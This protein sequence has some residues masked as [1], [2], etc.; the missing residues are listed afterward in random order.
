[1]L[2]KPGLRFFLG[3]ILICPLFTCSESPEVDVT[4]P[5]R[6][7]DIRVTEVGTN[8]VRL[9]WTAPGD[10]GDKGTAAK[11]DIRYSVSSL[12]GAAWDNAVQCQGEHAPSKAGTGEAFYVSGLASGTAYNFALRACDDAGNWSEMSDIVGATTLGV[13]VIRPAAITDLEAGHATWNSIHLAW[14][15][16][17][18]DSL[19]GPAAAYDIRYSTSDIDS[20][21]WPAAAQCENEPTPAGPGITDSLSIGGLLPGTKYYFAMRVGDEAGNWSGISNTASATTSVQADRVAPARVTDLAAGDADSAHV[22]L[23]WTATGDDGHSGTAAQ[24]DIR[25]SPAPISVTTWPSAEPCLNEPVPQPAGTAE[26]YVMGGLNP[27]STY[28]FA[29]KAAD[30]AGNWSALSNNTEAVTTA[31]LGDTIPPAAISSIEAVFH[32]GGS[33]RLRWTAVGDDGHSGT[34]GAFDIR[35]MEQPIDA[36]NWDEAHRLTCSGTCEPVPAGTVQEVIV[37]GFPEALTLYYVAVRVRDDAFNWSPVSGLATYETRTCTGGVPCYP[38]FPRAGG[39]YDYIGINWQ[40]Y[41]GDFYT[42]DYDVRYSR[43]PIDDWNWH[44]STRGGTLSYQYVGNHWIYFY[45][46]ITG[47]KPGTMYYIGIRAGSPCQDAIKVVT[48]TTE[49]EPPE[50]GTSLKFAVH[51]EDHAERSCGAGLPPIASRDDIVRRLDRDLP[52]DIDAFVVIFGIEGTLISGVGYGLTWP[53]DWG[54]GITRYCA[55]GSVGR[56]V[57]PGDGMALAWRECRE[58]GPPVPISWTWLAPASAGEIRI[59][60]IDCHH[61]NG[62]LAAVGCGYPYEYIPADSILGAGVNVGPPGI[63]PWTGGAAPTWEGIQ[64]LLK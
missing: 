44:W 54:T 21:T 60:G 10:D 34:A 28:Y 15:A 51:L 25:Y 35:C 20:L 53:A 22:T 32:A 12:S 6:V 64:S 31:M 52:C 56:I 19:A 3:L 29:M 4:P 40:V 9:V 43:W 42:F 14:T 48:A 30:E 55:D 2:R 7:N 26:T 47:L 16:T 24:Y 39:G 1:V 11:Y 36:G 45:Y 33:A 23:T 8:Y 5:A 63:E 46:R 41:K 17:G 59:R 58:V 49:G 13:D 57:N 27:R 37:Y 18:D 61:F 50:Y 38:F 62:C